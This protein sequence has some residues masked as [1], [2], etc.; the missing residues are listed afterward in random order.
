MEKPDPDKIKGPGGLTLRQIHA[1]VK[2]GAAREQ[3]PRAQGKPAQA[4]TSWQR[5]ARYAKDKIRGKS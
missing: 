4:R 5:L 1:Q 3:L 2:L